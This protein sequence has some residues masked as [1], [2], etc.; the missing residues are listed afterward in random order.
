MPTL[1][2]DPP[3]PT[4]E[5][6]RYRQ[7][8]ESFGVDTSRYDRTRQPYPQALVDRIVAAS[9]GR[10]VLDVGCGTGIAARQF[11]AAGC[12]V[13]GVEPDSRMADFARRHGTPVE[14]ATFEDWEPGDATF[15]T[16][17]AATAWHWIDPAIGAA[18]A[19]RLL[20][21]G[22]LFAALWHAFQTPA[23][24]QEAVATAYERIVPDSPVDLRATGSLQDAYR[25]IL[26]KAADALRATSAFGDVEEW[27]YRWQ[28]SYTRDEYLDQLPTQGI[29][30]GLETERLSPLLAAVGSAIDEYCGGGFVM[31]YSTV[32]LTAVRRPLTES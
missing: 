6:H 23:Q 9:P 12:D 14:V 24:V 5:P 3:S 27:R 17:I 7:M 28:R 25:P 31:E 13:R 11:Q 18:K 1:P 19:A 21:P 2:S 10:D 22:G 29:F 20:R 26:S 32:A 30:T 8:A 15:N 4:P 16:V